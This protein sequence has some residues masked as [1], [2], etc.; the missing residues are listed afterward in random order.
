MYQNPSQKNTRN[1]V[2]FI[3]KKHHQSLNRSTS[4]EFEESIGLD[5]IGLDSKKKRIDSFLIRF[6]ALC[7][8]RHT[9]SIPWIS[10]FFSSVFK[11]V[12]QSVF[13]DVFLSIFEDERLNYIMKGSKKAC[14]GSVPYGFSLRET[15]TRSLFFDSE[16]YDSH[17]N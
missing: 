6:L 15:T 4:T 17:K 1:R 16:G 7:A 5:W 14:G 11:D 9:L 3:T 13:E 2:I 10:F 8:S 12:L